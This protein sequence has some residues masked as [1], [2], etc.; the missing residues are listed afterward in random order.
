MYEH[1][2]VQ[3]PFV[4]AKQTA[5]TWVRCSE[6][7]DL[8]PPIR[9]RPRTQTAAAN[10]PELVW[11]QVPTIRS[12]SLQSSAECCPLAA[13]IC[14]AVACFVAGAANTH[15]V[16]LTRYRVQC[17]LNYHAVQHMQ[18]HV[19]VLGKIEVATSLGYQGRTA[20]NVVLCLPLDKDSWNSWHLQPRALFN[21]LG[22]TSG[23]LYLLRHSGSVSSTLPGRQGDRRAAP[24]VRR[25]PVC[26]LRVSF[27]ATARTLNFTK[28]EV[29][30]NST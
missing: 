7:V 24:M 2:L 26:N 15:V 3:P 22:R 10:A 27:P 14:A 1:I 28:P 29:K 18:R 30:N 23:T 5:H 25:R 11:V 21:M 16:I 6:R 13:F 12:R 17:M 8:Y 19:Q 20:E 4:R 9:P